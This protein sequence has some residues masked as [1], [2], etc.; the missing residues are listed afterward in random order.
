MTRDP[1]MEAHQH[2]R[3]LR[4]QGMTPS[5]AWQATGLPL[6]WWTPSWPEVTAAMVHAWKRLPPQVTQPVRVKLRRAA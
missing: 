2:A 1:F 4:L 6:P 5:Q 3:R